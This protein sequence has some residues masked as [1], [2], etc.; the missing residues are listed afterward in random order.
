M[1]FEDDGTSA[2][3]Y[4]TAPDQTKPVA[5]A[6]VYNR[7]APPDAVDRSDRSRPPALAK[8]FAGEGAVV[9]EPQRH[10]W[11]FRWSADGEAVGLLRDGVVVAAILPGR[12]RGYSAGLA[13]E[14]PWGSPLG[15]HALAALGVG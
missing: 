12:K 5:D 7:V 6:W 3:L 1:I 2:W 9:M 8:R 14:C 15:A 11:R 10:E 4:L 13:A